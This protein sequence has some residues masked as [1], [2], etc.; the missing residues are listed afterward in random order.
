MTFINYQIGNRVTLRY[1]TYL[2]ECVRRQ[3]F[4]TY[5]FDG[6]K[7]ALYFQSSSFFVVFFDILPYTIRK[8][9]S[10]ARTGQFMIKFIRNRLQRH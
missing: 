6:T 10:Y 5:Y 7:I 3:L 4:Q 2:S 1:L 9:W 8:K